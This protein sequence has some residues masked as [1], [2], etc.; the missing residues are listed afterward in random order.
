MSVIRT[1]KRGVAP[2]SRIQIPQMELVRDAVSGDCQF[3]AP[4]TAAMIPPLG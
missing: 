3:T 2:I 4:A 1:R